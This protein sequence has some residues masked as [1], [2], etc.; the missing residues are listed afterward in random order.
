MFMARIKHFYI[1]A[2][3]QFHTRYTLTLSLFLI[4][5]FSGIY[6][7]HVQSINAFHV[8]LSQFDQCLRVL[9]KST[10]TNQNKLKP[11]LQ[12]QSVTPSREP[13]F[14]RRGKC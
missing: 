7:I 10:M 6:N 1:S 14:Q 9:Q 4:F 13:D 3:P 5:S 2:V 8:S 11:P 12:F